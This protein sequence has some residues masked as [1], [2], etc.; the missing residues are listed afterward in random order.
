MARKKSQGTTQDAEDAGR[1]DLLCE[2]RNKG[3]PS[4][5][6]AAQTVG[7]TP[8]TLRDWAEAGELRTVEVDGVLRFDPTDLHLMKP[9]ERVMRRDF[10]ITMTEQATRLL[11]LSTEPT[12]KLFR[13]F[14]RVLEAQ[15]KR[16]T[17][18]EDRHIR[19]LELQEQMTSQRDE[20]E[21]DREIANREQ[22]RIDHGVQTLERWLPKLASQAIGRRKVQQVIEGMSLE[23]IMMLKEIGA[24]TDDQVDLLRQIQIDVADEREREKQGDAKQQA[25]DAAKQ[26]N[27]AAGDGDDTAGT[28]SPAAAAAM[29]TNDAQGTKND[30]GGLSEAAGGGG[31]NGSGDGEPG[32]SAQADP[33]SRGPGQD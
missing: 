21:M 15:A 2:A 33:S 14:E 23:Q 32:R 6:A 10:V 29:G 24:I 22:D 5:A 20:R 7:V 1:G 3:W 16:I 28:E 18:L 17:Q 26:A 12:E 19:L 25:R 13:T 9:D 11:K 31:S 4:V 30:D 8:R 27:R